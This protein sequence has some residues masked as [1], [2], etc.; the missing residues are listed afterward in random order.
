M[1]RRLQIWLE[2]GTKARGTVLCSRNREKSKLRRA[3][4]CSVRPTAFSLNLMDFSTQSARDRKREIIYSFQNTKLKIF[5]CHG[6]KKKLKS[7]NFRSRCADLV[8]WIIFPWGSASL[9]CQWRWHVCYGWHDWKQ[10]GPWWHLSRADPVISWHSHMLPALCQS[11]TDAHPSKIWEQWPS[12][13]RHGAAE[14]PQH[15]LVSG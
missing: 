14:S 15:P 8:A 12:L 5:F 4:N 9:N 1:K 7:D 10:R 3:P 13:T 2:P 6:W 11:W